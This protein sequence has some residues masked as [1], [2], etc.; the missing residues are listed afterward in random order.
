MHLF[1]IPVT[2]VA[3]AIAVTTSVNN[4]DDEH[5]AHSMTI[6]RDSIVMALNGSPKIMREHGLKKTSVAVGASGKPKILRHFATKA[7]WIH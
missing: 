1:V 6:E 4:P 7:N 2:I 3:I 5:F